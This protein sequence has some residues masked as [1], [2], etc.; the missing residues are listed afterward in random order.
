MV[1]IDRDKIVKFLWTPPIE[2][3]SRV[4]Y[5]VLNMMLNLSTPAKFVLEH[6]YNTESRFITF[7]VRTLNRDFKVRY[8]ISLIN[9]ADTSNYLSFEGQTS[10]FDDFGHIL[11]SS[12]ADQR[13]CFRIPLSVLKDFVFYNEEDDDSYFALTV[14]FKI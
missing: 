5:R 2:E 12:E 10:Y 8:K 13:K 14:E 1:S 4:R 7:F 11:D 6:T 9:R 3:S